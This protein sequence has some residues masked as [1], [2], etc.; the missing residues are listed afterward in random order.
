[1]KLDTVIEG[2]EGKCR[3]QEQKP[4]C[5]YLQSYFPFYFAILN[6]SGAYLWQYK[7][8]SNETWY[9]ERRPSEIVQEL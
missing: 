1:M 9:I 3:T 8:E 2:Y 5:Q 7:K 6:L 4:Y